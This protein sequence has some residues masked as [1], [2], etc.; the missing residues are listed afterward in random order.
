MVGMS[1]AYGLARAGERVR[2]LDDSDDAFRA[3]RGN[4]G[5]VW[6]QSKGRGCPPY[7]RWTIAADA[8]AG[9]RWPHE[10][11]VLTGIDVELSQVG[12]LS[13]CLDDD[14]LA[15][16]AADLAG[17][18]QRTRHR[19][20][21]R[22][23]RL[24]ARCARSCPY[25]GPEVVGAVFCPLDGHVNPLATVA[26]AGAGVHDARWR[27]GVRRAGREHRARR[28]RVPGPRRRHRRTWRAGSCWPPA[29][30]TA[31]W[32]RRSG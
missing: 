26:R 8:A 29:W 21:V 23:A 3:S 32:R 6:V 1:V 28:G 9:R 27:A 22:G 12:G 19:L 16:R 18:R 31:N 14:E 7:A 5:L 20:S 10:L 30:A 17:V 24:R 25:T 2:V 11:A 13:M 4:F 15:E